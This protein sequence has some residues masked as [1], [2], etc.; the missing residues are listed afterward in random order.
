MFTLISG[1]TSVLG[2]LGGAARF[3]ELIDRK[4]LAYRLTTPINDFINIVASLRF[5]TTLKN[6]IQKSSATPDSGTKK[7]QYSLISQECDVWTRRIAGPVQH[8]DG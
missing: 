1:F 7:D 2:G 8:N 6:T 5:I 4:L 3:F